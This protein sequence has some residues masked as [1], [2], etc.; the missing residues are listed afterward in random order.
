MFNSLFKFFETKPEQK[1]SASRHL[2]IE[3]IYGGGNRNVLH[4]PAPSVNKFVINK[5]ALAK[6][7][8]MLGKQSRYASI[9]EVT[10]PKYTQLVGIEDSNI[11]FI[12]ALCYLPE[13]NGLE[14]YAASR[15]KGI[16]CYQTK[17]DDVICLKL[18]K[19][20]NSRVCSYL[21][22]NKALEINPNRGWLVLPSNMKLD[23]TDYVRNG[24]KKP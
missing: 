20:G 13:F 18:I 3:T 11:L 14:K 23:R 12:H 8:E 2:R 10:L 5:E 4:A 1:T 17:Y 15:K 22:D 9:K 6:Q 24:L 19:R 16:A 7:K 21:I